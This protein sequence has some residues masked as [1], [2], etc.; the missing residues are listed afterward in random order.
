MSKLYGASC[1][2]KIAIRMN[3]SETAVPLT[4][5]KR[6]MPCEFLYGAAIRLRI[7][8]RLRGGSTTGALSDEPVTVVVAVMG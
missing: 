7:P 1:G 3:A 4:S 5:M 6:W 8:P 2:A